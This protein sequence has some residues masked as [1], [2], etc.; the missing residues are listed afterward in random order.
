MLDFTGVTLAMCDKRIKTDIRIKYHVV[1]SQ[2]PAPVAGRELGTNAVDC[3]HFCSWASPS[4]VLIFFAHRKY[5]ARLRPAACRVVYCLYA[6]CY[7]ATV[8]RRMTSPGRGA[9]AALLLRLTF[10]FPPLCDF[11]RGCDRIPA[12]EGRQC[13]PS[14]V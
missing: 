12:L 2:I 7:R 1:N 11:P 6:G 8:K 4:L 3:V 10:C 9:S 5:A 14:V 13:R